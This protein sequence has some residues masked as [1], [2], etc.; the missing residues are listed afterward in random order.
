MY[1]SHNVRVGGKV[2]CPRLLNTE[3]KFCHK[4]GHTTSRCPKVAE[5]SGRLGTNP[6]NGNTRGARKHVADTCSDGWSDAAVGGKGVVKE[7]QTEREEDIVDVKSRFD[8]LED[9][10]SEDEDECGKTVF[11]IHWKKTGSWAD[12][13]E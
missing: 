12:D 9:D 10:D 8:G 6:S 4:K 7:R 1:T 2:V 5:R 11:A 3:C 13:E